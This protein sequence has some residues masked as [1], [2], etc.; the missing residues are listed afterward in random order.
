MN[1]T[2]LSIRRVLESPLPELDFVLPGLLSGSVGTMVGPGSTGKTTLLLQLAMAVSAGVPMGC[3]FLSE[4]VTADKVVLIA[5]EET[6]AL[7]SH[8]I[9][10]IYQAFDEADDLANMGGLSKE[11]LLD[12]WSAN[13]RIVPA[14][15]ESLLLGGMGSTNSYF[16]GLCKY[17]EGS[18]LVIVD[19]L[20]RLH[21]GDENDSG[22]MTDIVQKLEVLAKRSGGAVLAAHHVN[23]GSIGEGASASTAS[24]GSSALT[25]GVRWQVNLSPIREKGARDDLGGASGPSV[26]LDFAKTN[27]LAPQEPLQYRRTSGGVLVS[28]QEKGTSQK[29]SNPKTQRGR[30]GSIR[31]QG[32]TNV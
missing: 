4:D 15:G 20:R 19:P 32:G 11:Q 9:S 1:L 18:R 13:L 8:R 14:A 7:L 28:T 5:A 16:E 17:C 22:S 10:A 24:R 31:A 21:S 25:D 26:K 6:A 2:S 3:G 12:L 30:R 27:Y 29:G 23:K